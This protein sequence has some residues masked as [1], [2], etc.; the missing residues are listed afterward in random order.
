VIESNQAVFEG[1]EDLGFDE[2]VN[3]VKTYEISLSD[4]QVKCSRSHSSNVSNMDEDTRGTSEYF[5]HCSFELFELNDATQVITQPHGDLNN[6]MT[7]VSSFTEAQWL[8][9]FASLV[10]LATKGLVGHSI[11]SN[12]LEKIY[13][14]DSFEKY[15]QESG[16][17][18]ELHQG[19][20]TFESDS[21]IESH[22]LS[23]RD[24]DQVELTDE[25]LQAITAELEL[26]VMQEIFSRLL[27]EWEWS[28][29][30]SRVKESNDKSDL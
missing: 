1:L 27:G 26:T 17:S 7:K 22:T 30:R 13:Q 29:I 11:K 24:F 2:S 9:L 3:V 6:L 5:D 21:M 23:E 16:Y 4:S 20:Y 18:L 8:E 28:V 14:T 15:E 19:V 10:P 12:G 25:D